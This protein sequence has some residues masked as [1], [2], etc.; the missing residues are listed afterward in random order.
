MD[1]AGRE[2]LAKRTGYDVVPQA[3]NKGAVFSHDQF[4]AQGLADRRRRLGDFFQEKMPEAAPVDISRCYFGHFYF[5]L[6]QRRD[7]AVIVQAANPF[8]G[9]G[10]AP[11]A[12]DDLA[13]S[14]AV[15]ADVTARFLDKAVRFA[16]DA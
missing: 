2:G 16:R 5:C 8:E 12:R 11:R 3:G 4:P 7:R 10:T 1:A 9:T 14:L 13:A 6:A 15:H